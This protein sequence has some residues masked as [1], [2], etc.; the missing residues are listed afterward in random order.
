[1]CI[2]DSPDTLPPVIN[3]GPGSPT[4]TTFG[5]GAKFPAKYQNAFFILDWSWGKIHAIH[6]KPDGSTYS[7]TKET[8]ITGS[9]L[10]VTDIIIH[11]KDGAMY[12]TIGGRKVQSGMYRVT[13]EGTEST[14]RN[15]HT[16][17]INAL[18]KLRHQLERYHGT[19]HKDAIKT[20]WPLSLIHI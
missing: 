19:E 9:P 10:P 4:G 18:T 17:N 13:Y 6:M 5:Y 16:S 8:F 2:R 3:I 12:F 11:P 20:V 14:K 7:A 15:Q 1:M